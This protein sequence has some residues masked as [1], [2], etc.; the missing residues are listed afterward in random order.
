MEEPDVVNEAMKVFERSLNEME[1][2]FHEQK[3]SD[4]KFWCTDAVWTEGIKCNSLQQ[5][6]RLLSSAVYRI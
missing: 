5:V 1:G 2:S 4:R 3:F 6:C